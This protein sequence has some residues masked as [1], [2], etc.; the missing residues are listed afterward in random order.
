MARKNRRRRGKARRARTQRQQDDLNVES[1]AQPPGQFKGG[2]DVETREEQQENGPDV[3]AFAI[4]FSGIAPLALLVSILSLHDLYP[5]PIP[6]W[7]QPIVDKQTAVLTLCAGH[8]AVIGVLISSNGRRTLSTFALV[9]AA[10]ATVLAGHRTIGES[11]AGHIV[12]ITL[13]LLT[14]TVALAEWLSTKIRWA[15]SFVRS[16][17]GLSVILLFLT[18][19][20]IAYNQSQN[21]NYIRNWLLIPLGIVAVIAIAVCVLWL[22]T[23]LV[24]RYVPI[25]FT[26]VSSKI[27][28]K[29]QARSTESKKAA[30]RTGRRQAGRG[31]KR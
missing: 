17:K 1:A 28:G 7:F 24:K 9:T 23:K 21:E 10:I 18:V 5:K 13:F 29:S 31:R 6:Q 4:R 19:V 3:L 30:S 26:W 8:A 2:A 27:V 14:V 25:M 12:A 11:T 20:A 15:L 16:R 22:V